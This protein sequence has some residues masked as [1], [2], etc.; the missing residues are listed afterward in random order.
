MATVSTR[1]SIGDRVF[2]GTTI[3]TS[4]QHPCPDCNGTQKWK[5]TSPAGEEYSFSCP[6]CCSS[7]GRND[8]LSLSYAAHAALVKPLTIG[9]IRTD[10]HDDRPVSYMCNET[11]VGS[12]NVYYESDLF[13]TEEEA[14]TAAEAKAAIFDKEVEWVAQRY[15]RTLA[16]SEYSLV[17]AAKK[18]AEDFARDSRHKVEDLL[19]S[20]DDAYDPDDVRLAIKRWRGEETAEEEADEEETEAAAAS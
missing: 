10:S 20:L 4:K 11:G 14:R 1:Y 15:N 7:Y 2:Y 13:L 16:L 12:G 9:S 19:S 6:R 17:N 8:A 3:I 5:T 18:A